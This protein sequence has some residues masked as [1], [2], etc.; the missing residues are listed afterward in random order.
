[1]P[2]E[3]ANSSLES[4]T[5]DVRAYVSSRS[6]KRFVFVDTP[7][8]NSKS[9]SQD[10]ALG[11]IADW[12]R[13][14][15]HNSIELTG[16]IFTYRITDTHVSGTELASLRIASAL[17]GGDAADRVRLVTTMW[18]DVD[19]ESAKDTENT[20]KTEQWKS[21]LDKGAR[22]ERFYNTRESAWKIIDSL[23]NNKKALLLQRERV[24]IGMPLARTAAG[25]LLQLGKAQVKPSFPN[26]PRTPIPMSEI[27]PADVVIL[28]LGTTGS[29]MSNNMKRPN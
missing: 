18:D 19:V 22:Y 10:G 13:S 7:G 23:G 2:V 21:L 28:V 20:M 26:Y 25:R 6:G 11:M 4:C 5:M 27:K 15:Y 29:G 1:M 3:R 9:H 16:V 12:L 17:C 8:F 24:D 14:A